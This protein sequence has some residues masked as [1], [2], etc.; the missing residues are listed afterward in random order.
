MKNFL[1]Q[2]F[3]CA[4]LPF[5][6]LSTLF[7]AASDRRHLSNLPTSNQSVNLLT[8]LAQLT[9]SDGTRKNQLGFSIAIS[10]STGGRRST[11]RK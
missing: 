8:Q 4:F 9:A 2:G 5:A 3:V 7:V 1:F 11:R 6:L 10:G